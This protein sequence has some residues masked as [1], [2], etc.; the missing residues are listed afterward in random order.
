[1][2]LNNRPRW[3]I[4]STYF[5][6]LFARETALAE[7]VG[8]R[9]EFYAVT[10][11]FCAGLEP[12]NHLSRQ[13]NSNQPFEW[14]QFLFLQI[15]QTKIIEMSV[16][17]LVLGASWTGLPSDDQTLR[18]G[19]YGWQFQSCLLD[20]KQVAPSFW[21]QRV[22]LAS[23][24]FQANNGNHSEDSTRFHETTIL[25]AISTETKI[26]LSSEKHRKALPSSSICYEFT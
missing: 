14:S 6:S 24:R 15:P 22:G 10:L 26:R 25:V 20:V 3:P 4:L 21:N 9:S 1:M 11:F 12:A 2:L 23:D 17:P 18:C 16:M 7:N 19:S 5:K 13:S 8:A